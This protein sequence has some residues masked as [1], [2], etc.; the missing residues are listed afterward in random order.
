MQAVYFGTDLTQRAPSVIG[1]PF[2][3]ETSQEWIGLAHIAAAIERGEVVHIR[4]ATKSEM[5]RAEAAAALFEI[6]LQIAEKVGDLLDHKGPE[7]VEEARRKLGE[8]MSSADT[9]RVELFDRD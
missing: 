4:P 6:G 7:V 1:G 3:I 8:A 2:C 9:P 5:K